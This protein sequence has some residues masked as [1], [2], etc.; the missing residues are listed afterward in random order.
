MKKL[1]ELIANSLNPY[2]IIRMVS[3]NT[4]EELNE[5]ECNMPEFDNDMTGDVVEIEISPVEAIIFINR[6][7]LIT[8]TRRLKDSGV[9]FKVTNIVNEVFEM[10]NLDELLLSL[11]KENDLSN[12]EKEIL[13]EC[14]PGFVSQRQ[15]AINIINSVFES[16]FNIDDVLDRINTKGSGSLNEF[17]KNLLK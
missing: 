5:I 1:D 3:S 2:T 7:D 13:D 15:K 10:D 14:F 12:L 6:N 17:H 16:N 9:N 8:S 11:D 4:E